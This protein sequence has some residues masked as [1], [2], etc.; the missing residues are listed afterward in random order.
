MQGKPCDY[1]CKG[2]KWNIKSSQVTYVFYPFQFQDEVEKCKATYEALNSQL[3][4]ELP[5]LIE[6]ATSIFLA[7]ISE[8]ILARKLF[9]GRITKELLTLM[10]VS[11]HSSQSYQIHYTF[12]YC[13]L[14]LTDLQTKGNNINGLVLHATINVLI[15]FL[16]M[17]TIFW[18]NKPWSLCNTWSMVVPWEINCFVSYLF[19]SSI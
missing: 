3:I 5:T 19:S 16:P 12:L 4:E 13:S 9:V 17:F 8:F 6:V 11:T 18:V 15:L 7:V 10:D 14:S 1:V 2:S